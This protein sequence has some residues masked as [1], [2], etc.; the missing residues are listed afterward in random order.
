VLKH[1]HLTEVYNAGRAATAAL[2]AF[3]FSLLH[4]AWGIFTPCWTIHLDAVEYE[5]RAVVAAAPLD[6]HING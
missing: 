5:R 6:S 3:F 1:I 2:L 4:T